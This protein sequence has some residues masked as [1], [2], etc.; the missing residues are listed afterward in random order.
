MPIFNRHKS[1]VVASIQV[2]EARIFKNDDHI[3]SS[4]IENA[5]KPLEFFLDYLK[6]VALAMKTRV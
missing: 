1:R 2:P 5:A 6:S 3:H 4:N